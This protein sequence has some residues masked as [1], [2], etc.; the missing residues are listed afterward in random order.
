M[1]FSIIPLTAAVALSLLATAASAEV[2]T[3]F[4]GVQTGMS[5]Q[6]LSDLLTKRGMPKS[7][8]KNIFPRV[9]T[10]KGDHIDELVGF[11]DIFA[12]PETAQ[13]TDQVL[14]FGYS[15]MRED[16]S[17][18]L[19]FDDNSP[20]FKITFTR[21]FN[22]DVMPRADEIR[23]LL[24]ERFGEAPSCDNY[25]N[26]ISI[27]RF[28]AYDASGKLLQNIE[29]R[30]LSDIVEDAYNAEKAGEPFPAYLVFARVVFNKVG[31][32]EDTKYFAPDLRVTMIDTRGATKQFGAALEPLLEKF[33]PTPAGAAIGDL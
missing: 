29:C 22:H 31:F 5:W 3:K 1:K 8:S 15:R 32:G 10:E 21:K 26:G 19:D 18:L 16:S 4:F 23:G 12:G 28:Y 27:N 25:E 17:G 9:I 14:L 6:Q 11:S 20:V 7:G 24:Q 13:G 2:P 33:S 30:K